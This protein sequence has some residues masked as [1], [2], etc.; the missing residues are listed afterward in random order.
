[1]KIKIKKLF[2]EIIPQIGFFILTGF[3]VFIATVLALQG[4]LDAI[5]WSI[6]AGIISILQII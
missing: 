6:M 2:N 4:S 3:M 1:M 5:M